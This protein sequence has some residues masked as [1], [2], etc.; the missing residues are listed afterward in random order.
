MSEMTHNS[1]V[2]D[3]CGSILSGKRDNFGWE[4]RISEFALY[5]SQRE[6]ESQRHQ[7]RQASQ[8]LTKLREKE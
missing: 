2:I 5:E 7:L 6:L 1:F 8:W 3:V 4:R